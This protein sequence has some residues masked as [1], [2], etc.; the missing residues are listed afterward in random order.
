MEFGSV[1]H[2]VS[3]VYC[4]P[5]T[6]DELVINI[7]TGYDIERVFV[8]YGDPYSHGI[9]GSEENWSGKKEEIIYKK[10][11]SHHIWWTTTVKPKY[12]RLKY[13]FELQ[14]KEERYFFF[15]DG[16]V[17]E[18]VLNLP[19]KSMQCFVFPWM[20]IS[21]INTTPYW[22][23]QTVWYQIFPDRF[24]K[25]SNENKPEYIKPW[26]SQ[27][28]KGYYDV[29][30]GDLKGIIS[31]LDY[32][33][34]L[35]ITGLYLTPVFKAPSNH[36]YDTT[37]YY[38]VDPIFGTNDTLK[39][40]VEKCH[41]R[42]IK[43]MLDGVF[44]HVGE[45]NPLWQDV[46]ANGPESKYYDWFMINRWPLDSNARDT[47]DGS[48]YSFAFSSKMPKLNT[49]NPEVIN[50][51]LDICTFWVNEFHID[52][53]RLDVANEISHTLNKALRKRMVSLQPDFYILGEIW[54]NA[55]PWLMGD[56][57]HSVMNYPLS[58]MIH[59]FWVN[60]KLTKVDFE[61]MVN[62]CYTMYMQQTNDVLFNLLDSHDTARLFTI[63]NEDIDVFY[64]QLAVLFVMPGAPC[65]YYGTEIALPGK[66]DPDCRRAMPW[67]EI[68][69]GCYDER[70]EVMKHLIK[71]RQTYKSAR[72]RNFHFINVIDNERLI[73]FN[74]IEYEERMYVA[75]NASKINEAIVQNMD[76]VFSYKYE[77]RILL[78][79]GI[80]MGILR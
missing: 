76:V 1:F 3:G 61:Y 45:T 73:E 26:I 51:I 77:D 80:V 39:E 30:G 50:Y 74:K 46:L 79:G 13:Y 47:R 35:G 71:M 49:N 11:L 37:D 7:K 70:I 67:D 22:V 56:E 34:D 69:R 23:N 10:R 60:S 24:C 78:S 53:L 75:I 64:Q 17:S 66:H 19:G 48:F 52:A 5:V 8:Y 2:E 58:G 38:T 21:D 72:S 36:K 54:H 18:E 15:E 4:Y 31:K 12:K 65:I 32:L 6:N 68:D 16:F 59:D 62:R 28:I 29:Y 57:F 14:T 41:E 55:L 42:G 44:N 43:V 25:G 27:E 33:S 9:L 63:V 40:L 20:N